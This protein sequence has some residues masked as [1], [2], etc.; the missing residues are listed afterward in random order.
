MEVIIKEYKGKKILDYQKIVKRVKALIISSNNKI[1]L[2]S[3]YKDYQFPGGH[4]EEDESYKEALTRELLEETGINFELEDNL[5]PDLK[6]Y[7]YYENY[8]ETKDNTIL[9]INY[10]IIRTDKYIDVENLDL[11]KEEK[12][13]DF[14]LTYINLLEF[15]SLLKENILINGDKFGISEEMFEVFKTLKNKLFKIK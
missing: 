13:G 4:I 8:H 9:E 3:N 1:L 15:E 7:R 10:F 5:T 2:A 6:L 11:T 12:N 14:S